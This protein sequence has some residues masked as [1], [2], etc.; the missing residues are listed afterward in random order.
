MRVAALALLLAVAA[1][2]LRAAQ[3]VGPYAFTLT[4]KAFDERCVTLGAGDELRFR[5]RASAPVDFNIH[6]HRGKDVFYPVR[7]AGVQESA[8]TFRASEADDYCLM[9]EHAGPGRVTVE[10]SFEQVRAH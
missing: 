10:C 9:W 1:T 8:G 4:G 6:H 2:P 7:Q 5:F 3:E